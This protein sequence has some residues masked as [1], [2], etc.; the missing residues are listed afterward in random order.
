MEEET[1][2]TAI[3][4]MDRGGR[5]QL[6]FFTNNRI[7]VSKVG[8]PTNATIAGTLLA[9]PIGG[10]IIGAVS[11]KNTHNR[12]ETASRLSVDN[13]LELDK[14]SISIYYSTIRNIRFGQWGLATTLIVS[15]SEKTYKWMLADIPHTFR[16]EG[17]KGNNW[18]GVGKEALR[19]AV[20]DALPQN[21]EIS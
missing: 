17:V 6:L 4:I 1:I 9:G 15:S 2:T 14:K 20:R 12:S 18:K 10:L 13:I 16:D 21:V 11:Y 3:K 8:N 19:Q 7:I 5:Q